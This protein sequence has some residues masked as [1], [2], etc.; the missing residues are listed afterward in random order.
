MRL[1][2]ITRFLFHKDDDD[3]DYLNEDGQSI[4]PTWYLFPHSSIYMVDGILA[5]CRKNSYINKAYTLIFWLF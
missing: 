5:F 3:L 2:P 4:E 1:S